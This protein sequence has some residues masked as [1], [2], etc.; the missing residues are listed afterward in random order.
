MY[1]L[2]CLVLFEIGWEDY[3]H[4]IFRVEGFPLQIEV[5]YCNGFI[6][7]VMYSKHVTFS[8][9]SLISIFNC[10]I[11]TARRMI[12]FRARYSK[13]VLILLLNPNQSTLSCIINVPRQFVVQH[14]ATMCSTST[15]PTSWKTS[16][17][18]V[19]WLYNSHRLM[20]TQTL[21]FVLNGIYSTYLSTAWRLMESIHE[22]TSW[23]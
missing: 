4:D 19:C 21:A 6:F 14:R 11:L 20:H 13:F 3:S 17:M 1:F 22:M 10:N 16:L 5:I 2:C 12:C 7:F 23:Q 9:F 18:P 8:T 15:R